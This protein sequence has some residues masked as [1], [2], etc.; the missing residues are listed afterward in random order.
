MRKSNITLLHLIS[1]QYQ[2]F[3]LIF[4]SGKH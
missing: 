4:L 3:L 1:L 2:L